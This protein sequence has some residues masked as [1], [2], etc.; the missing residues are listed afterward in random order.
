MYCVGH[1]MVDTNKAPLDPFLHE[2]LARTSLQPGARALDLA[3]GRGRHA[4]ELARLGFQ[5]EAWDQNPKVLAELTAAATME[6]LDA[7]VREVDCEALPAAGPFD[8]VLV[9][10]YLDRSLPPKLLPIVTPEA[11]FI[12]C[13]FTLDRLGA[14]PSDRWCLEPGELNRGFE[15]WDILHSMESEGRAGIVAQRTPFER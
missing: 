1:V 7:L 6:G 3:C 15:G 9:F 4:L 14:H 8:L 10:N 13:T 12:Y 11:Y 2:A 5:V